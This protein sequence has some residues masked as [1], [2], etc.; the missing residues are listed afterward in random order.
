MTGP[1]ARKHPI[2]IVVMGPSGVG[3]TTTAQRLSAALGWSFAEG[4][5]FHPR[6]NIERMAHGR[7]LDDADRAPWLA[8]IRD[9]ISAQTAAG[10]SVV[11]TCS[12]LKRSYRDVLRDA[13][14]DVRFVQLVA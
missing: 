5:D 4:D 6:A 2:A 14:G 8:G 12:A 7:P 10:E 1:D 3:K 9:W 13:G 11:V